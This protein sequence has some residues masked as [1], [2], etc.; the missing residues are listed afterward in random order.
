MS[1]SSKPARHSDFSQSHA[2][3]IRGAIRTPETKPDS[4]LKSVAHCNS[5]TQADMLA[6]FIEEL[7]SSR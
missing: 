2:D 6:M 4:Q 5:D 3:A 7:A 1:I